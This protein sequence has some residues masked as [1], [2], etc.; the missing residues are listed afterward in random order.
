MK[1]IF[2]KKTI[3]AALTAVT[4]L[5]SLPMGASAAT[6]TGWIKDG[7][8][9]WYYFDNNGV[10]QKD[11]IITTNG[12]TYRLGFDG[13]LVQSYGNSA[14]GVESGATYK[15]INVGSGKALDVYAS[16]A[17]NYSN[18]DIYDDNSTG[19]QKW[20][21][22]QY[23]DGTFKLINTN[24]KKALDVYAAEKDNYSNVDIYT[25]NGTN[26]QKWDIVA[27]CD[28]TYKLINVG[29]GKVLDV[30][31]G[32]SA[33]YTNVQVYTDNGTDAQKWSLVRIG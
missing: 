7:N 9:I 17:N 16:E 5:V 18:V 30:Y 12:K 4:L 27:N 21:I 11:T 8:G 22:Y 15:L 19:A 20:T 32:G 1:N 25:E 29:S 26:A 28:G 2:I 24:S 13:A 31:G 3:A 6:K 10:M 23:P 14:K 33:N